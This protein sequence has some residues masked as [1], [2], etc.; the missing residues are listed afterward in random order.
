ME[1]SH[2]HAWTLWE[3]EVEWPWP[4]LGNRMTT[5]AYVPERTPY[6]NRSTAQYQLPRFDSNR[7]YGKKG[8]MVLRCDGGPGCP[9]LTEPDAHLTAEVEALAKGG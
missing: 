7:T 6:A 1:H 2:Y 4:E 5:M 9:M 8:G 3:V